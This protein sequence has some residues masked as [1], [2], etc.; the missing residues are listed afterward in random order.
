MQDKRRLTRGYY[1][2]EGNF[3]LTGLNYNGKVDR[4][5]TEIFAT[6]VCERER[7]LDQGK[8]EKTKNIK[9]SKEKFKN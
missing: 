7:E 9:S 3:A 4:R 1:T 5:E 6:R 2:C 8:M